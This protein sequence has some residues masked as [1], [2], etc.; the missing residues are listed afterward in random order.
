MTMRSDADQSRPTAG[1][2]W[3]PWLF[4][5]LFLVVLAANGTMIGVALSTF[6]GLETTN[7]YEKGLAYN[8]SLAAAAE[9]EQLGWTVSLQSRSVGARKVE[10]AV[11]LA[12]RLG[13]PIRS[14]EVRAELDRPLQ[15]G[16]EQTIL[17]AEQV[18]GRYQ[19]DLDLPLAGQ[20]TVRLIAEA[21]D[22]R[23]Q[24]AERIQVK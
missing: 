11:D 10:L 8:A 24:L 20:W 14:A 19:A 18:P 5:G 6:N 2:R 4:V 7:A 16:H 13:Q 21:R 23:Y 22:H 9:Q 17:L 15:Q 1:G 3:I 12:D